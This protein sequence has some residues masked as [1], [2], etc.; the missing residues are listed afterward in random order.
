MI[1]D[2]YDEAEREELSFK[3]LKQYHKTHKDE[4]HEF[5]M[6]TYREDGMTGVIDW[7]PICNANLDELYEKK[8]FPRSYAAKQELK[9]NKETSC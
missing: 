1:C 7:C 2:V 3:M 9:Q 8:H 6:E 5:M 4:L